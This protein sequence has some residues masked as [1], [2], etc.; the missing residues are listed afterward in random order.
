MLHIGETQVN[1]GMPN[2]KVLYFGGTKMGPIIG[3][4]GE[5]TPGGT[6]LHQYDRVD[7]KATVA[8][9]WTDG[10]GQ[11]Y[12]V[13]VADAA[14][15][16][17]QLWSNDRV[18]T[19]L[20]NYMP[21]SASLATSTESATF[22]MDIIKSNYNLSTYPA[23]NSAYSKT[24]T[25]NRITY[26]GL[27]PNASELQMIYNDRATLDTYD[28][29]LTEY[30]NNDLTTW[31]IEGN[32]SSCWTSVESDYWLAC[33]LGFDGKWYRAD[34]NRKNYGII[35]IFEIPVDENGRVM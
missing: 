16:S 28:P 20:P 25:L 11:R 33:H 15:R 6:I 32:S 24:L 1:L 7:N 17:R 30:L 22:N 26:N 29:T 8:G 4:S 23:F 10:N 19:P 31:K 35:P 18:D 14:Y 27:L 9:F 21:N 12:A 5:P 2:A 13:C 34:N 3:E